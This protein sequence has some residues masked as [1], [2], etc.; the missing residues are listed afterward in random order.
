[1]SDRGAFFASARSQRFDGVVYRVCSAGHIRSLLSMRGAYL[2]GGRYNIR[3]YFGAL[4][5]SLAPATARQEAARYYTVP[6]R[7]GLVEAV[8]G[9]R[10]SR[11]I[12]LTSRGEE[13]TS[14]SYLM[15]QELGRRAWEDGVEAL[16]VPSAAVAGAA[17]LVLF[18]DNQEARWRVELRALKHPPPNTQ[19]LPYSPAGAKRTAR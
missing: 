11:L 5:T 3:E 17:N 19:D 13:L 7:E 6:P 1:M 18:L 2:H 10:L 16:L 12:D 4:Y 9:L 8:I 15:S 14:E